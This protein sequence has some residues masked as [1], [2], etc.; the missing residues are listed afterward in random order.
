MTRERL[1]QIKT[2]ECK[3]VMLEGCISWIKACKSGDANLIFTER[4]NIRDMPTCD[5]TFF[6]KEYINAD[7]YNNII[8]SIERDIKEKLDIERKIF[9]NM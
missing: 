3:I 2:Q 5:G 6:I 7:T 4:K 8:E 9:D 1:K